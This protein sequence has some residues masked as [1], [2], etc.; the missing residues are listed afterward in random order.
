MIAGAGVLVVTWA[1]MAWA[2]AASTALPPSFPPGSAWWGV[3]AFLLGIATGFTEIVSRYRD[4][5]MR[6][7]CDG[8]GIAYMAINGLIAVIAF[9][10]VLNYPT[11]IIKSIDPVIAALASGFGAM[12]VLRARFFTVK[13][14]NGQDVAIGPAHVVDV[15]MRMLDRSIDRKRARQR[16]ELVLKAVEGLADFDGVANHLIGS[17]PAFQNL[18][19]VEKT[20]FGKSIDGYR[21]L[22]WA[23]QL[24]I[25]ALCFDFL[26]LVG[27]QT[28]AAIMGRV[29]R[30]APPPSPPSNAGP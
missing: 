7:V 13:G 19:D 16:Y 23:A 11:E 20:A 21:T 28:F 25:A 5:P 14:D 17:L 24:K 2:Q 12:L 26:N 10:L 4:E 8:Y 27:E 22:Q 6:A 18:S 30:P 1:Q 3:I 15:L 29:K 9:A